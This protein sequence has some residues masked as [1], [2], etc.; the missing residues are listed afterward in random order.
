[1]RILVISDVHSDLENL[2]KVLDRNRDA[3][4]V[5]FLGDIGTADGIIEEKFKNRAIV[6]SGNCDWSLPNPEQLIAVFEGK[7]VFA[8]HGHRYS[9]KSGL[10]GLIAEAKRR[11]ADI[12]F[13]GHTHVP[14]EQYIDGI[15]YLNPGS[16]CRKGGSPS[17]GIVDITKAGIVTNVIYI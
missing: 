11:N 6:L 13:F 9:V 5:I 1:M 17:Y 14:F 12:V 2:I 3:D 8:C 4:R 10:G 16:L 15:Y 7:K